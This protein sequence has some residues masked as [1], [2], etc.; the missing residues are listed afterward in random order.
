MELNSI[1]QENK[2]FV[3]S[4]QIFLSKP[5]YGYQYSDLFQ[6]GLE[7]FIKSPI[8]DSCSLFLVDEEDFNLE[9]RLTIPA[10]E[11][12]NHKKLLDI[13]IEKEIIGI[14]LHSGEVYYY[15]KN[16][17]KDVDKD[18]LIIPLVVS[19]GITGI[20]ILQLNDNTMFDVVEYMTIF[21]MHAG[22]FSSAIERFQL[23]SNL[24]NTKDVLDQSV[25]I[26]TKNYVDKE[27]DLKNIINFLDIGIL[28]IDESDKIILAN[29]YLKKL[30]ALELSDELSNDKILELKEIG[31]FG[32]NESFIINSLNV[33]I[34]VI[35]NIS[36]IKLK[37]NP[38]KII[39]ILDISERKVAEDALLKL[40]NELEQIVKQRTNDLELSVS[41]LEKEVISRK[42]AEEEIRHLFDKE[43]EL[44]LL[45]TKFVQ[46][47]SHELR[48]P[49]TV[50]RSTAQLIEL[51]DDK[52]SAEDKKKYLNRILNQVDSL[53]D[54]IQNVNIVESEEKYDEENIREI[55]IISIINDSIEHF[56]RIQNKKNNF[57]IE[58]ENKEVFIEFVPNLFS[59]MMT[60]LIGN[61]IK[62]SNAGSK[63]VINIEIVN[64]NVNIIITDEGIGIP[65]NNL[66][67]IYD[68]FYRGDNVG[69]IS[70]SGLGLNVVKSILNSFKGNIDIESEENK[71][72]KVKVTIPLKYEN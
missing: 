32:K 40:N 13:F 8:A 59:V 64:S 22:L 39:S 16:E 34:P 62:F 5:K 47:V 61:S 26:R 6:D 19:W 2:D 65:E 46:T 17:I 48:T 53:T 72:T 51:Y 50:I 31:K 38:V 21:K 52:L 18:Y 55:E 45:K 41:N 9:H 7:V 29:P 10:K 25:A 43:K 37:N 36:N 11:E 70:G 14:T 24:K 54:I 69:A 4:V 1:L 30:F 42:K 33:K 60:N 15:Q 35:Y 57:V 63:V 68:A 67:K 56:N 58:S 44:N 23:F 49:L 3:E 66:K 12:D 71:G 27:D 20:V 28:V